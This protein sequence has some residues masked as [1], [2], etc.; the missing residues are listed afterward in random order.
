MEKYST[1]EKESTRGK[2]GIGL[3]SL[4]ESNVLYLTSY[5][6]YDNFQE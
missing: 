3:I 4:P 2:V 6:I 5:N 1:T